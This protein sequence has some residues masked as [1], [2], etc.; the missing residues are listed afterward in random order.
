MCENMT[1]ARG[2]KDGCMSALDHYPL[3]GT[4]TELSFETGN[5]GNFYWLIEP[6]PHFDIQDH[7]GFQIQ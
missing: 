4:L 1:F 6:T 2:S 7:Y 5:I 3:D